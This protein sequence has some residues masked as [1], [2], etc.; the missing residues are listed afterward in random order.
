MEKI[1][2]SPEEAPIQFS[3][4]LDHHELPNPRKVFP[5]NGDIPEILRF[6]VTRLYRFSEED[7]QF[8][9]DGWKVHIFSDTD[10][11]SHKANHSEILREILIKGFSSISPDG[12]A[13]QGRVREAMI[14]I[15]MPVVGVISAVR[16]LINGSASFNGRLLVQRSST[17]NEFTV[18]K[19]GLINFEFLRREVLEEL[20][21]HGINFHD[22]EIIG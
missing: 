7:F 3:Y 15:C 21:R 6:I 8:S 9:I 12:V 20:R 22:L 11:S 4:F 14:K 17:L 2:L 18:G 1:E 19:E 5:E 16:A 13:L 10:L